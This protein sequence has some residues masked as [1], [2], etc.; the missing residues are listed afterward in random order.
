[1]AGRVPVPG[2]LSVPSLSFASDDPLF[3]EMLRVVGGSVGGPP[4]DGLHPLGSPA[5]S[6]GGDGAA[7]PTR[8][9]RLREPLL[10]DDAAMVFDHVD[11]LPSKRLRAGGAPQGALRCLDTSHPAPC[12]LCSPAPE[13]GTEE[14]YQL[15]GDVGKKNGAWRLPQGPGQAPKACVPQACQKRQLLGYKTPSH[16][17]LCPPWHPVSGEKKLRALLNKTVEWNNADSREALAAQC[18]AQPGDEA[19]ADL[20]AAL[21]AKSC[22]SLRKAHL[23]RLCARWG[24][25]SDLWR[26][27][28]G[29]R[30][31]LPRSAPPRPMAPPPAP[32]E[33]AAQTRAAGRAVAVGADMPAA[34]LGHSRSAQAAAAAAGALTVP[35]PGQWDYALFERSALEASSTAA[36]DHILSELR[37]K[38]LQCAWKF[39]GAAAR[40]AAQRLGSE[41]ITPLVVDALT[42][43]TRWLRNLMVEWSQQHAAVLGWIRRIS[44]PEHEEERATIAWVALTSPNAQWSLDG[45]LQLIAS[46]SQTS[47]AACVEKTKLPGISAAETEWLHEFGAGSLQGL[48][49]TSRLQALLQQFKFAPLGAFLS[50]AARVLELGML[51]TSAV[52]ANFDARLAWM[53]DMLAANRAKALQAGSS[54]TASSERPRQLELFEFKGASC[55]CAWRACLPLCADSSFHTT[56]LPGAPAG[57]LRRGR[58][59]A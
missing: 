56:R 42:K 4:G 2:A 38:A 3:A 55:T 50:V 58:A 24:Y 31:D 32:L 57:A 40:E 26:F 36:A 43:V 51:S 10:G 25:A 27:K 29:R 23:L 37:D 9:G 59:A 34:L 19:A 41:H 28:E 12:A 1:M 48:E 6:W 44:G 35:Q 30:G 17:T 49:V 39:E 45:A 5:C 14:Q 52:A 21:R 13:D 20:A 53:T 11:G 16:L 8:P 15:V 47:V 7:A 22:A 18:D 46:L 33:L 54:D